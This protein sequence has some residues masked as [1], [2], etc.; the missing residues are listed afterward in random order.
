MHDYLSWAPYH[1][2]DC[3]WCTKGTT[4]LS[5]TD[6]WTMCPYVVHDGKV[7]PDVRTLPDSPAVVSMSQSVLYNSV[8]YA[9][10][11]T[12]TYSQ[13]AASFIDA[14]FLSSKTGMHPNMNFGQMVRGPGKDHQVGTFTGVLDLRGLVKVVN[15]IN[16]LKAAGSAD[17]TSARDKAMMSWMNQYIS[18]LQTSDI[19][20]QVASKA[21]NHYTFYVNQLAA[22]KMYVGDTQ[23]ATAALQDYFSHQYLDQIAASGE[24][25]FEAVRTRPYHYRCFNLEAMITNAKLGDQ[26]G[27]NLWNA[28]SKYG[29]TIQTALDYTMALNPKGEDVS[30]IFPHVAAIAAAYGDPAG[31]YAAFLQKQESNYKSTP[32]WFYDQTS[33]LPN[34]PA[35]HSTHKREV[36]LKPMMIAF[37]CPAVFALSPV[38]ELEDGLYVTCDQLEPF[39]LLTQ[40]LGT[41]STITV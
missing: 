23:G 18:W 29:A 32:F 30:D 4:H 26:L 17:W 41:N 34:S 9:L 11:K 28:K 14:F 35:A 27:V 31:K 16:L 25:P 37:S 7:N 36:G 6:S 10:T 40:P 3:N 5:H 15:G 13:N 20:K 21:N 8:A 12:G 2:P 33:A 22:A 19:G 38:T 24:Q 1:W 39:Y